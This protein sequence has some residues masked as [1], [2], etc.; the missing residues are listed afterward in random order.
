[1]NHYRLPWWTS[2]STW[3]W[4][5]IRYQTGRI[6]LTEPWTW[7]RNINRR[8]SSRLG[9]SSRP[10]TRAT[11]T[12]STWAR[13]FW[14]KAMLSLRKRTHYLSLTYLSMDL[15]RKAREEVLGER[16]WKQRINQQKEVVRN[17]SGKVPW[18]KKLQ[19]YDVVSWYM[20]WDIILSLINR[21]MFP[22]MQ[23]N[24]F[25]YIKLNTKLTI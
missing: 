13:W 5:N 7:W 6:S 4:T 11:T 23:N 14:I 22:C 21:N 8:R 25:A 12:S 17:R 19:L 20:Y 9:S 15:I 18:K 2:S 10:I 24:R 1:M 3:S 16:Q